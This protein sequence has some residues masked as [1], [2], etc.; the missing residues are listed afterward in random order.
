VT[1][2]RR[3]PWSR[4]RLL[5]VLSV[6]PNLASAVNA[7]PPARPSPQEAIL[8]VT[9]NGVASATPMTLL[10]QGT[11]LYA[12][13]EQLDSWRIAPKGL[14]TIEREGATYYLVNAIPGAKAEV[15]E[16]TQELH[17]TV[18][19]GALK[20]TH[21]SFAPVAISDKLAGG[22][23][24]FINY[25]VSA[26]SADGHT[27]LGGVFEAGLFTPHGVGISNFFARTGSGDSGLTRLET[28]W[29]ID[30]PEHMRTLRVGDSITR[31]GAGGR[32]MRFAGIQFGRNFSVWPGFVTF[33]LPSLKGAANIPSVADIYVNDVLVRSADLPPGPFDITDVPIV[34]GNGDVQLIVRDMLGRQQIVTQSYYAS[35]T[36]LRRGLHDY[37]YEAGFLRNSFGTK[38]NDYGAPVIAATHR[39][40]F[41]NGLTG[42]AHAEATPKAQEAGIGGALTIPN[43]GQL[44]ATVA[45]SR[46]SLGEGV[47]ASVGFERRSHG[48]SLGF[49]GEFTTDN[50]MTAAAD[51]DHRP[52]ASVIQLFA[53]IPLKDSS[54]GF[55]YLRRIG[56]SEPD[57]GIASANWSL[58]LGDFGSLNIAARESLSVPRD[59]AVEMMLIM[60]LG[61]RRSATASA[62]FGNGPASFNTV[63]QSNPSLG[64]G[65]GYRFS[66]ATGRFE[67]LE[68]NVALRT[69]S[70]DYDAQLTWIDGKTGVRLS[71]AGSIGII[72]DD[73]FAAR[74]L[75]QSFARVQVGDYAGVR[76]YADNQLVGRTG[77]DGSVLV[78]NLRP[79]DRNV[80]RID[81]ND[82][83]LNVELSDD[84]QVVRPSNRSGVVVD[85]GAK[86]SRTA[87]V[88]VLVDQGKPLPRGSLI[89]LDG[90]SDEFISAPGGEVYLTAVEK[91]A[92]AS[93]EWSGGRCQFV[94][95]AAG[96]E[97]E[98]SVTQCRS[99]AQ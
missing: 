62:S 26:E 69:S 24:A 37:S 45:A 49:R 46:S 79:Y 10:R 58:R 63:V 91:G 38:S 60:P 7:A 99:A 80:I 22:S 36:Q 51:I 55:T 53:G 39:Y 61:V 25:D 72:G 27:M 78:P 43:I 13:A 23:G 56:R 54:I 33:P 88:R 96:S 75:D 9:V 67:R 85:F 52:A 28:N 98:A 21:L 15:D 87:L 30:D 74:R 94:V 81:A 97:G 65:I 2:R 34:T 82:L 31:G 29:T 83:P 16:T 1:R 41:S 50:F 73:P 93:A 95:P 64:G 57:I 32:P 18:A 90:R 44:D 12:T 84:Q 47:L 48:L 6:A 70:G 8:T 77:A 86:P 17:L 20:A 14:P 35:L 59:R 68:G 66:A 76:I 11:R 92:I 89:K 40:G 19:P 4:V 71:T 3:S 5:A 42:E